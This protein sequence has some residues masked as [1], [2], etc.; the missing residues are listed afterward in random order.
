[1]LWEAYMA[2]VND[3]QSAA[4]RY[5][6]DEA[7]RRIADYVVAGMM[8]MPTVPTFTEPRDALLAAALARDETD[9]RLMAKAFARRGAGSCAASPPRESQDLVGVLESYQLAP[10]IAILSVTMDEL[11]QGAK[12]LSLELVRAQG[13]Q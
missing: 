8:L 7:Q 6:F 13:R 11:P 10:V 12:G 4:A 5:T 1:M 2:L 3:T 9:F